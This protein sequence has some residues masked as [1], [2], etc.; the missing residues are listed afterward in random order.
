MRGFRQ[1]LTVSLNKPMP[2]V[3]RSDESG[4]QA[5]PMRYHIKR[6]MQKPGFE[7]A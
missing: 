7:A 4:R 6:D 3:W 5:R 2:I 1:G